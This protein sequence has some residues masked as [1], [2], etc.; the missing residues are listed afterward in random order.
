MIG[1]LTGAPNRVES[2]H[3]SCTKQLPKDPFRIIICFQ[4]CL[5]K[6]NFCQ[7]K[8]RDDKQIFIYEYYRNNYA[9]K[10]QSGIT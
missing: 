4:C 2:E 5:A 1:N 3:G 6:R 9:S 8:K 10:T 7:E